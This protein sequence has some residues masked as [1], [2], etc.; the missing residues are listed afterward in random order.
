MN[1]AERL[2]AAAAD[3]LDAGG[4]AAVTLRA[5]GSAVGVSHNAPYKHFA[6]RDELLAAVANADFHALADEWRKVRA[7]DREPEQRLLDALD[8][9][10]RFSRDHPARYRLLFNRPDI[11]GLGESLARTADEALGEFGAIVADGQAT[12]LLP[13]TDGNELAILLFATAHGLIDAE[14]SGRIL[15]KTGWPEIGTG[16]QILIR[17][18]AG[19]A[20]S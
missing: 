1:T 9:A 8:V 20:R 15:P 11:A 3:L 7:S 16:L 13:A 4:D 19:G 5:V 17:L 14:A 6:S 10:V 2:I 18:L 12:G